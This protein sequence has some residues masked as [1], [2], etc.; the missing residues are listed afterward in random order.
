MLYDTGEARIIEVQNF[1]FVCKVF[2]E[3]QGKTN[4]FLFFHFT[5]YFA[6]KGNTKMSEWTKQLTTLCQEADKFP[7]ELRIA[8]KFRSE[9]ITEEQMIDFWREGIYLFPEP[10][11]VKIRNYMRDLEQGLRTVDRKPTEIYL[12]LRK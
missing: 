1:A 9:G 5:L 6:Q 4:F 2:S 8:Y 11:L 7:L 3:L 10:I 12:N